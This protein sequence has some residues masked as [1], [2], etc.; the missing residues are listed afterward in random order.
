[1]SFFERFNFL[2]GLAPLI[3]VFGILRLV[4]WWNDRK[5]DR[6]IK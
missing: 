3:L 1:M 5:R 4:G 6:A 2:F